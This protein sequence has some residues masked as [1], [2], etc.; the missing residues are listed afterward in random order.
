MISKGESGI[1]EIIDLVL[2]DFKKETD[3]FRQ[4]ASSRVAR[5]LAL[6]TAVKAGKR[7]RLEEMASI[8]S[9]LSACR[10]PESSPDGRPVMMLLSKEELA[11]KF[12]T[13]LNP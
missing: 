6:R 7:L 4:Q 5:S 13:E 8:W 10:A 11:K 2:E 9:E 12:K 1:R 3:R